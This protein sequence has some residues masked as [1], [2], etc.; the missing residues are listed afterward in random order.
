MSS[1][2]RKIKRNKIKEELGNNN[3]QKEWRKHQIDEYSIEDY[4]KMYKK[5]H[6]K[7]IKVKDLI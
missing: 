5:N 3:I 7:K 4:L 2:I 6:N 1:L